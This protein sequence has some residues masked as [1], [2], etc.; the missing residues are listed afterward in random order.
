MTYI[1]IITVLEQIRVCTFLAKC[2]TYHYILRDKRRNSG[3]IRDVTLIFLYN[4]VPIKRDFTNQSIQQ[5]KSQE[6]CC[7]EFVDDVKDFEER[8]NKHHFIIFFIMYLMHRHENL[9]IL[10]S[11][12]SYNNT[13]KCRY[14][15]VSESNSDSIVLIKRADE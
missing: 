2:L 14:S 3:N 4:E 8:C 12:E 10:K 15:V 13:L 9:T 11:G 6:N 7:S 1:S 5:G